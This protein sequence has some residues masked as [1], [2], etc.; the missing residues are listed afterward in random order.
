MYENL[1]RVIPYRIQPYDNLY[2]LSQRFNTDIDSIESVNPGTDLSYLKVGQVI[3]IC[4]GFRHS[5]ANKLN[6]NN[7]NSN[8]SKAQLDLLSQM[9][10]LW[11]DSITWMRVAV[12][13]TIFNL[14]DMDFV[15]SR[16]FEIP[17]DFASVLEPF[18]GE[19]NSIK[20]SN[21]LSE[22]IINTL[23]IV[24]AINAGDTVTAQIAEKKWNT[25]ADEISNFLAAINPNWSVDEWKNRMNGQLNLTKSE[26]NNLLNKNYE[27]SIDDYEKIRREALNMGDMMANGIIKQFPDKFQ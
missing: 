2:M 9:R 18:Y 7:S 13:S 1:T 22:H 23:E 25:N 17:Q 20:F 16:L 24:M 6:V 12:K 27:A 21:L 15:V 26:L 19:E 5:Y 8:I 4:T 3:N 11:E 10:M 14:P